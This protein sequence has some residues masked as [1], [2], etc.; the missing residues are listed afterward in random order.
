MNDLQSKLLWHVAKTGNDQRIIISG[1][2]DNIAVVY[3]AVNA[4]LIAAAPKLLRAC[5]AGLRALYSGQNY[6]DGDRLPNDAV[7]ELEAAISEAEEN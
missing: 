1:K 6:H 7:P 3:D 2:G 5:K 4:P